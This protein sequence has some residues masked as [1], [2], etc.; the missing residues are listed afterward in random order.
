MYL[1]ITESSQQRLTYIYAETKNKQVKASW[2]EW[3][4]LANSYISDQY[5]LTV[6]KKFVILKETSERH[7]RNN[8]CEN[9]VT[10]HIEAAAECIPIKPRAKY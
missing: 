2:N 7:T 8:E 9:L 5:T 10:A 1:P 6:G 4:S 3:Y